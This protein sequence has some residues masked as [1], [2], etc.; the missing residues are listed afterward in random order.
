MAH[1]DPLVNVLLRLEGA[2][3]QMETLLTEE[4]QKT[5]ELDKRV[6]ELTPPPE[7]PAVVET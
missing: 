3:Q 1:N 4:R 5:A 6:A 7:P 2:L